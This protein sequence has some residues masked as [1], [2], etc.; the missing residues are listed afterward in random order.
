MNKSHILVLLLVLVSVASAQ[1]YLSTARRC[2]NN[3][4]CQYGQ[5]CNYISGQGIGIC[6]M[7]MG[8]QMGGQG[9]GQFG[10]WCSYNGQCMS[11]YCYNGRCSQGYGNSGYGSG[12][13]YNQ[14]Y[15]N[16]NYPY[17]Q[18]NQYNQYPYN[19]YNQ[20][21]YNQNQNYPYNQNQYPYNQPYKSQ[22]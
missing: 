22:K 14:Q 11:N 21:P 10:S 3:N 18:Y 7:M 6:Q 20:Y 17:N 12:Y 5:Y 1:Q 13:G 15:P 9:M 4:Q 2:Y 16:Q 19:Q 8:G